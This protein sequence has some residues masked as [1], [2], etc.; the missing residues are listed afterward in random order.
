MLPGDQRKELREKIIQRMRSVGLEKKCDVKIPQ[1][2]QGQ[3]RPFGDYDFDKNMIGH[4][5]DAN[6]AVSDF[7]L[8]HLLAHELSHSFDPCILGVDVPSSPAVINYPQGSGFRDAI[9][10]YPFAG[11][12]VCLQRPT[13]AHVQTYVPEKNETPE[14]SAKPTK[15]GGPFCNGDTQFMETF[16]EWMAAE[17][18]PLFVERNQIRTNPDQYRA[19][20]LGIYQPA[21][22]CEKDEPQGWNGIYANERR[23]SNQMLLTQPLIRQQMGCNGPPSG[24]HCPAANASE[25]FNPSPE[26]ANY[27]EDLSRPTGLDEQRR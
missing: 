1:D 9:P 3:P 24:E 26:T 5:V 6:R 16:C 19:G 20:Y 22:K 12:L 23:I 14:Q 10:H 15:S 8:V 21:F 27:G 4:C 18:V 13:S 17:I 11:L 7:Q 2:R 25:G